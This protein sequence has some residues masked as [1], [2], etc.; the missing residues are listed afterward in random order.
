MSSMKGKREMPKTKDGGFLVD[1][2]TLDDDRKTWGR[3]FEE[4]K[5][6]AEVERLEEEKEE[7]E[8]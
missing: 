4:V 2:T 6:E 8:E 3:M 1:D 7:E 5:R